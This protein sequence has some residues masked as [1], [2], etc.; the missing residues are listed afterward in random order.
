MM[1]I[2]E[3]EGFCSG[4]LRRL[5][6]T[7]PLDV[8]RNISQANLLKRRRQLFLFRPDLKRAFAAIEGVELGANKAVVDR[9]NY[10]A[11]QFRS[12]L[13]HQFRS[14]HIHL[15]FETSREKSKLI[16]SQLRTTDVRGREC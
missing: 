12:D 9:Q 6:Q 14:R 15:R 3:S 5:G 16:E 8:R 4:K 13:A 7:C 2:G 1:L 11:R 10:A